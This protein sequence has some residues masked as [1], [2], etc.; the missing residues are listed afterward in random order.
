MITRLEALI[1]TEEIVMLQ[2]DKTVQEAL[3]M[4]RL[5]R[6]VQEVIALLLG[7]LKQTEIIILMR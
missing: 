7:R 1:L 2:Q 6:I 5:D 3:T 4:L